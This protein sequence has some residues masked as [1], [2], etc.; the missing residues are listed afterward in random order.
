[1][2]AEA[3]QARHSGSSGV[4]GV[5][6]LLISLALLWA[7]ASVDSQVCGKLD[8]YACTQTPEWQRNFLSAL[9][10]FVS[11]LAIFFPLAGFVAAQ[12]SPEPWAQRWKIANWIKGKRAY[13][14]AIDSTPIK[15][16]L[17]TLRTLCARGDLI[18]EQIEAF[19][20]E[21]LAIGAAP[22]E[23]DREAFDLILKGKAV[24]AADAIV[25]RFPCEVARLQQAARLYTPYD[26]EKARATYKKLVEIAKDPCEAG[27]E[28]GVLE[29]Q[30]GERLRDA[31]DAAKAHGALKAA[32]RLLDFHAQ[33]KP[34][35]HV[36]ALRARA[37][38]ADAEVGLAH[39]ATELAT[40]EAEAAALLYRE[41]AAKSPSE[42]RWQRG[43]ARCESLLGELSLA[44]GLSQRATGHHEAALAA[45]EQ[46]ARQKPGSVEARALGIA[47][48][49]ALAEIARLSGDLSGAQ[50]QTDDAAA[51]AEKLFEPRRTPRERR[52]ARLE[53]LMRGA[54]FAADAGDLGRAARSYR[55]AL[56]VLDSVAALEPEAITWRERRAL[57][58]KG[59]GDVTALS[60]GLAEAAKHYHAALD[61]WDGLVKGSPQHFS[62]RWER[63]LLHVQLARIAE[64]LGEK[65][66]AA[67]QLRLADETISAMTKQWNLHP[68]IAR[69]F[70]DFRVAQ[71]TPRVRV[72]IF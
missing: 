19:T 15:A 69:A 39:G 72:D 29:L 6:L 58:L 22:G 5:A 64:A 10:E 43:I 70:S 49:D 37:A 20:I 33:D 47:A 52:A 34:A 40:I 45:A 51:L 2:A 7:S 8:W 31:D 71:P 9:L 57:I 55:G 36:K 53:R 26:T 56:T 61:I 25:E 17:E 24:K 68:V 11:R 32:R 46:M 38:L 28:Y 21:A 27:F 48:H 23:K 35:D 42:P 67:L 12:V 14:G 18:P 65:E 1:M 50:K 16:L 44:M 4:I 59:L 66:D 41:L 62:W 13:T 30:L 54:T 60:G 3:E 63:F